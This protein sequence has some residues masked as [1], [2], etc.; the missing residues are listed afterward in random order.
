MIMWE[1]NHN[2]LV[3]CVKI[4]DYGVMYIT[5][6]FVAMEMTMNIVQFRVIL[7]SHDLCLATVH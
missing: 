1:Y 4:F 3:V 5:L 2:C 7:I 6:S